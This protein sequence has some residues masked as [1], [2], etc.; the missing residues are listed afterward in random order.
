M[1]K[2]LFLPF[3]RSLSITYLDNLESGKKPAV[4]EKSLEKV[5]IFGSKSSM[6]PDFKIM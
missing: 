5:L 3:L 6:N 2:A 1:K 4:L